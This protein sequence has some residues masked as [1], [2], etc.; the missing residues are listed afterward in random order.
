[1]ASSNIAGLTQAYAAASAVLE[2]L[3]AAAAF[4]GV[5]EDVP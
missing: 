1:M 5:N 2:D 4:E 3:H